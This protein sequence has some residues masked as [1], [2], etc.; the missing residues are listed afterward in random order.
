MPPSIE[1]ILKG[2]RIAEVKRHQSCCVGPETPLEE[3][4]R[5]LDEQRPGA[6][7]VRDGDRV[8]G[9]FTERDV[10]YRTALEQPDPATPI[11]ELATREPVTMRPDQRLAEAIETMASK[12]YRHLPLV[13]ADG[14]EAG[15]LSS[16]DI[17]AFIA[18]HVPESVLNLPP[19][20]HQTMTSPEGG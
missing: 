16:R 4:Y 8:T 15:L 14:R 6:V 9:I 7:V 18:E 19:K 17:L 1:Q 13:D 11:G 3:V 5:R 2:V 12:G 10:L 20:L